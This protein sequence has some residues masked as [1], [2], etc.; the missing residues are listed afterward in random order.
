MPREVLADSEHRLPYGA[1]LG[2]PYSTP[3]LHL[4]GSSHENWPRKQRSGLGEF[5]I[6]LDECVAVGTLCEALFFVL[7][8][9]DWFFEGSL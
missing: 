6:I 3:F 4:L 8:E 5:N 7:Q 9:L 1:K 2:N